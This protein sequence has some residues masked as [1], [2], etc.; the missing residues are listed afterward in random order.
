MQK[1]WVL[2]SIDDK[3]KIQSLAKELNISPLL[4]LLLIQ[5]KVETYEDARV[6]FRPEFKRLHNPFL[7][8]DMDKAI[9]RIEKAIALEEKIL[10]YGDYDVDGTTAVALISD[11]LKNYHAHIDCYIPDRYKEGYGITNTG[12]DYAHQ[13]GYTV[14][15]ALDC[16][17]RSVKEVE[18]ARS[19]G[20]D[21]II[22]D[23]HLP[24][25]K[26]PQAIAVL[27]PKRKDCSYPYKELPGCGIA[28][29]I[30]HAFLAH[31]DLPLDSLYNYLDLVT[32]AIAADIVPMT[33]ENRTL[34]QLGFS[35]LNSKPCIGLQALFNLNPKPK[36]RIGMGDLVFQIAPRINAAGRMD[37][38][39]QVVKLLTCQS[40]IEAIELAKQI[41]DL[42]EKRKLLDREIT[43]EALSLLESEPDGEES[44]MATILYQ[45]HWHKGVIG[46]VASRLIEHFHRPTI[47]LTKSNGQLTGSARS[48]SGIDIHQLLTQCQ[49]LLVKFGGHTFAAGMTLEESNLKLFKEKVNKTLQKTIDPKVLIRKIHIDSLIKFEQIDQKFINIIRQ[50]EPH[51]PGNTRPVFMS[52]GVQL[53]G[54]PYI[55]GTNHLKLVVKQSDS[56]IFDCIG[57]DMGS[58]IDRVIQSKSLEI[59][60]SIEE[61]VWNGIT[62]VQLNLKAIREAVQN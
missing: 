7:M 18:Y 14:I 29:K 22:G 15:L 37:H 51:G 34:S 8:K 41:D 16:G 38:A 50:F 23:H 55:V 3:E 40:K 35:K 42:N 54:S 2:K 28:F 13:Q 52:T 25:D 19:L 30:A 59:C 32:I 9:E 4:S 36:D 26:L 56:A 33:G 44:P 60:Y 39:L 10:I 20:I 58:E 6:F 17:I 46:I 27:D 47:I 57:F 45:A 21:F 24:G 11:F 61:N 53:A 31:R 5:R 12:I 43:E 49:D 48:I 1:R 62:T